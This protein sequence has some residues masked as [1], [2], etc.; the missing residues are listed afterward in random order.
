[1]TLGEKEQLMRRA[2]EGQKGGVI[3]GSGGQTYR[4]TARG[5]EDWY[6]TENS[7]ASLYFDLD[8]EDVCRMDSKDILYIELAR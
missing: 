5:F 8:G 2:A 6:Q 7:Y 3:V 1:M 4:G